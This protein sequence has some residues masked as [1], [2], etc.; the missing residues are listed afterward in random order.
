MH[1]YRSCPILQH[2]T[3]TTA[4]SLNIKHKKSFRGRKEK[5]HQHQISNIN[6]LIYSYLLSP[7]NLKYIT[8]SLTL[9]SLYL[10][11]TYALLLP[12]VMN[13]L[14]LAS[15]SSL[16]FVT[17]F[18]HSSH[19]KY[20]I[21]SPAHQLTK[22]Q[23]YT[24]ARVN[25]QHHQ[26]LKVHLL[27]SLTQSSVFKC[28]C[29]SIFIYFHTYVYCNLCLTSPPCVD[30]LIN[31]YVNFHIK[32]IYVNKFFT[33]NSLLFLHYLV[34]LALSTFRNTVVSSLSPV[35]RAIPTYTSSNN[36][37]ISIE[38]KHNT[39]DNTAHTNINNPN[40]LTSTI[41]ALIQYLTNS[42][43]IISHLIY[44]VT[45]DTLLTSTYPHSV[46]LHTIRHKCHR[47]LQTKDPSTDT[48]APPCTTLTHKDF[49]P[50]YTIALLLPP[51]PN[52][53]DLQ[54]DILAL[55]SDSNTPRHINNLYIILSLY[56]YLLLHNHP[57]VYYLLTLTTSIVAVL[58]Y[59]TSL[60]ITPFSPYLV[61]YLLTLT[62]IVAVLLYNTSLFITPFSPY[63]VYY[64]LT[65]TTPIVAV[66]LY[67]TSLFITPF[68]PYLVYYL[69]TLTLNS[70]STLIQYLI[71]HNTLLSLPSLLSPHPYYPNSSS[72]LI[73]YLIIH[74][75]LLSLPSLLSPHPYPQ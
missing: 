58:L 53:K 20:H 39:K 33:I 72:T 59:N 5:P 50:T 73:Q 64:L 60:F 26:H 65:L 69:L 29:T 42:I 28:S 22:D 49:L 17:Y 67:N 34:T 52:T 55:T 36:G 68:S 9:H 30:T 43:L 12:I 4:S 37:H 27:T 21:L 61:Y 46:P 3:P 38:P 41:L 45:A 14:K 10:C 47:P 6:S 23:L 48:P 2:T 57:L 8:L 16:H 31:C 25:S 40:Y 15:I 66:L 24:Q 56:T 71:I 32:L 18:Q 19:S 35:H 1:P 11:C 7:A 44:S 74:N 62:L 51:A 13:I 63:L 54:A 75:T 70:S